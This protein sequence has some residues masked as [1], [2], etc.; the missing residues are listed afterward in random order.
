[1][2][3]EMK[4]KEYYYP[5]N[6][7]KLKRTIRN[8]FIMSFFPV[9]GAGISIWISFYYIKK[10]TGEFSIAFISFLCVG[11]VFFVPFFLLDYFAIGGAYKM[12]IKAVLMCIAM[13]VMALTMI[14]RQL[15]YMGVK[16]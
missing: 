9:V 12:V 6:N 8:Q 11:I 10:Y 1:M 3:I 5:I 2:K 13:T 15:K 16:Q 7:N 14:W 4:I